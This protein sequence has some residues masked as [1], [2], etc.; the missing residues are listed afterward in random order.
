MVTHD[1][2][3]ARLPIR[4]G[5]TRWRSSAMRFGIPA[6]PRSALRALPR[7]ARDLRRDAYAPS[8]R[9]LG[10]P[11]S[12]YKQI[13]A[14]MALGDRHR[15]ARH[16][17][18]RHRRRRGRPSLGSRP[19]SPSLRRRECRL[20]RSLVAQPVGRAAQPSRSGSSIAAHA[21]GQPDRSGRL[22]PTA[23]SA[24]PAQRL[25]RSTRST[26]RSSPSRASSE[27][28]IS[29]PPWRPNTTTRSPQPSGAAA[30]SVSAQP[31]QRSDLRPMRLLDR[32]PLAHLVGQVG[33]AVGRRDAVAVARRA[34]QPPSPSRCGTSAAAA[35]VE[36][37]DGVGRVLGD[38]LHRLE[39]EVQVAAGGVPR[40]PQ[41]MDAV[42]LLHSGDHHVGH[43]RAGQLD[44]HV[45]DRGAVRAVLDDLDRLDVAAGQADR[46]RDAAQAIQARR[47][48]RSAADDSSRHLPPFMFPADFSD[49]RSA[50]GT[51]TQAT[52]ASRSQL[53]R[54]TQLGLGGSAPARPQVIAETVTARC[55]TA[56]SCELLSWPVRSGR[57][58]PRRPIPTVARTRT[59]PQHRSCRPPRQAY[60]AARAD[61]P[62]RVSATHPSAPRV[63]TTTSGPEPR[64]P[65]QHLGSASSGYNHARSSSLALTTCE[66]ATNASAR[67]TA[68]WRAPTSA[69]RTFGSKLSTDSALGTQS[70]PQRQAARRRR[71]RSRPRPSRCGP[72]R[73]RRA[74]CASSSAV[75]PQSAV[76][77]T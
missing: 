19:A 38:H 4:P 27:S 67:A 35:A 32:Q 34:A 63:I 62:L 60:P 36:L 70:P 17:A 31:G 45:V 64:P 61:S 8:A 39:V 44:E 7:P 75:Q 77:S 40:H 25:P 6:R 37:L 33:S 55:R 2:A 69:G 13:F 15:V 57:A 73:R 1:D 3:G 18:H 59:S 29:G 52:L 9:A 12:S 51:R 66:A 65:P 5:T 48:A 68:A 58:V 50:V 30:T 16:I 24:A 74:A 11:A 21:S 71:G 56:S 47:A 41:H 76:P 14:A 22:R 72:R 26:Q 46:R 42:E 10:D 28:K 54:R 23:P 43:H 53:Q 49:R 20:R